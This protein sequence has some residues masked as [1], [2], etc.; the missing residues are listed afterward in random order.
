M[1]IHLLLD[2][3][4]VHDDGTHDL[5]FNITA[6]DGRRFRVKTDIRCEQKPVGLLFPRTERNSVAKSARLRELYD[7]VEAFGLQNPHMR[8]DR[9][10]DAVLR[11]VKGRGA[12][13]HGKEQPHRLLIT[14]NVSLYAKPLTIIRCDVEVQVM[15][16]IIMHHLLI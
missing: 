13:R 9:L 8:S 11:I 6:D 15:R 5:Y 1:R 14:S 10:K 2:K 3:Q 7:Q 16:T 4:V 12:A